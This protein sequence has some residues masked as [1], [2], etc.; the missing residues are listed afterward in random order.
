MTIALTD[1]EIALESEKLVGWIVRANHS[2]EKEFVF[3][4]F[5]QAFFMDGVD[6][7]AK[8]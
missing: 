4:D 8:I 3:E 1:H 6:S 5:T 7:L 2:I